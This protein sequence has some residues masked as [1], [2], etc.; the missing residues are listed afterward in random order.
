MATA[1]SSRRSWDACYIRQRLGD[2]LGALKD[3]QTALVLE[4]RRSAWRYDR[5]RL[6]VEQGRFEEAH[7]EVLTILA[8]E[9]QNMPGRELLDTVAR[10]LAEQR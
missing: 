2:P 4:P 3:Y 5:A 10:G 6:L 7:H 1:S 9:P 8:L